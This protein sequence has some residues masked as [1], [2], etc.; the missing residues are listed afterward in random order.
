MAEWVYEKP[1]NYC[2]YCPYCVVEIGR[3]PVPQPVIGVEFELGKD[4][5]TYV[6]FRIVECVNCKRRWRVSGDIYE[7]IE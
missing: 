1:V 2:S 6:L 3:P 7:V 5:G 4:V